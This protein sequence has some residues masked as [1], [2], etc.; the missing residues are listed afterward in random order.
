[1]FKPIVF[2]AILVALPLCANA[3]S[4]DDEL[5]SVKELI[6]DI[7]LDLRYATTDNFLHQK[8]YTINEALLARGAVKH[9]QL[10]QDSLRKVGLG[11]KI[12]DGYRPRAIQYLMW[13]IFPNPVY[14]ADP[15]TGSNHNRGGAVDLT[16]V[17]RTTGKELLMPTP[18]DW[19]GPEAGHDWYSGLNAEQVAN[20]TLLKNMMEIVGGFSSYAS[21]WWHYA[22]DPALANPLMDFQMK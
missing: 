9:L 17:D 14:V 21:E 18:F 5:V 1:M 10:V 11:L 16:L 8:L 4:A 13:E 12:Y 19:F 2:L 3:Q 22:Y 7:V 20:R 6:P 15:G